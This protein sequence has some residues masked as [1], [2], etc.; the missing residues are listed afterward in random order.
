MNRFAEPF[1]DG[2]NH[3]VLHCVFVNSPESKMCSGE[4]IKAT[5]APKLRVRFYR[6]FY[7]SEDPIE[8]KPA[9]FSLSPRRMI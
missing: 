3:L 6:C 7:C 1:H 4:E 2:T 8:L 5:D 9:Y